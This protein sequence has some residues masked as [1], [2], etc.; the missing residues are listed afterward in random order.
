[1]EEDSLPEFSAVALLDGTV[2]DSH[3]RWNMFSVTVLD[4]NGQ[5]TSRGIPCV[6]L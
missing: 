4:R 6:S 3:R 1:M 2:I 5:I